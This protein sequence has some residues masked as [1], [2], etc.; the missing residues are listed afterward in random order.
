MRNTV[1]GKSA[2]L[3]LTMLLA[4]AALGLAQASESSDAARR[5]VVDEALARI[6]PQLDVEA[7]RE[8]PMPGLIEIEAGGQLFYLSADGRHLLQGNLIDTVDR[9]DLSERRRQQTRSA[10]LRDLPET[11]TIAFEAPETRHRV[12]VFTALDCGY[13]RRFH[14]DIEAYREAGISIDYVLLPLAGEG[15]EADRTGARLF[16]A[17]D[18]QDAFTRATRGEPIEGPMCDS[19]YEEGKALAARLGIRNTPTIVRA[20]GSVSGYQTPTELLASL[21]ASTR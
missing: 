10:L 5:A 3:P 8:A 6:A 20:D 16:C 19:G 21:S 4:M 2:V 18:R 9:V 12:T 14:A 7:V 17:A 15:S 1:F 11:Q 13:C